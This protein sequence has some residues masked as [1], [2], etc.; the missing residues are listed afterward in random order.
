MKLNLCS[1]TDS[2]QS[3]LPDCQ[4]QKPEEEVPVKRRRKVPGT[5]TVLNLAEVD[6]IAKLKE[7]ILQTICNILKLKEKNNIKERLH[8]QNRTELTILTKFYKELDPNVLF[9]MLLDAYKLEK[10]YKSKLQS[11]AASQSTI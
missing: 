4:S 5:T 9:R 2:T 1:D 11:R 6:E 10:Q 7:D 8:I 3:I